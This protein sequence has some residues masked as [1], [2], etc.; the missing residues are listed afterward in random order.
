MK[1][2][3]EIIAFY[4]LYFVWLLII[5][6]LNPNA[7]WLTYF[8]FGVVI[9]YFVFLHEAWD[10]LWFTLGASLP[11][12]YAFIIQKSFVLELD[13]NSFFGIPFWFP[14]VWGTTFVALRKFYL[15][16]IK[17]ASSS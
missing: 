11:L 2:E 14:L 9:F 7:S 3:K 4:I 16:I 13:I 5:T 8:A 17:R 6:F 12:L 1:N 15:V 10:Q